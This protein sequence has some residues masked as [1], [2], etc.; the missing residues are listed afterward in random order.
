VVYKV[1]C[2]TTGK[3]YYIGKTQQYFKNRMRGHF[4]DVKQ[5]VKKNVYSDSYAKKFGGQVPK[6]A[7]APT[8]GM[9]LQRDLISSEGAFIWVRSNSVVKGT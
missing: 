5:I 6:G 2:K 3:I 7:K 1:K 9:V 8:P 4:Q